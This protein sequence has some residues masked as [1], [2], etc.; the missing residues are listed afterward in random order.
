M[1]TQMILE[2]CGGE[3]SEVIHA[4]DVPAWERQIDYDPKFVKQL[5]GFDIAEDK[6]A[7]ILKALGFGVNANSSPWQVTSPPWRPDI[8]G[9]ADLVEEVIRTGTSQYLEE[10][11]GQYPPGIFELLRV[12]KLGLKAVAPGGE[13]LREFGRRILAIAVESRQVGFDAHQVRGRVF[14]LFITIGGFL[15]NLA[16]WLMGEGRAA[17]FCASF[18]P[19]AAA[20]IACLAIALVPVTLT[21]LVNGTRVGAPVEDVDSPIPRGAVGLRVGT[22]DPPVTVR[23][24]PALAQSKVPTATMIMTATSAAIGIRAT[25][26]PN[27]TTRTSRKTPARNV[28]SRV[29]APEAFTL[30]MVWPIMAQPPMPPKKPVMMFAAPW[31]QD[32]RVLLERVSVMSSTSL[33]VI[34]DSSRPT[35]AMASA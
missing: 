7:E 25:T 35:K 1:A 14:G 24:G 34:S 32:S 27:P 6:Q 20:A 16:H 28:E 19:V 22:P 10:L 8:G 21:L 31:P 4:G 11:R 15:G 33:A 29:R 2:L 26:S 17:R 12:P 3:A 9:K 13:P 23:F 30:I 18:A 5:A